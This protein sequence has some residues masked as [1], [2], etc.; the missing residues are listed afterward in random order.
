RAHGGTRK[1]GKSQVRRATVGGDPWHRWIG[2]YRVGGGIVKGSVGGWPIA[3][4][5]SI[6]G[7]NVAQSVAGLS[8]AEK[9]EAREKGPEKPNAAERRTRRDEFDLVVVDTETADAVRDLKGNDQEDAREDR[10]EHPPPQY[11]PG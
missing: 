6:I 8:Q 2:G 11:T 3:R 9:I 4:G 5:V 10:Q 1:L 7:T